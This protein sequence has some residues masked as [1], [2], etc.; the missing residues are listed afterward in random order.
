MA[1]P[2][3]KTCVIDFDSMSAGMWAVAVL[4]GSVV[5]HASSRRASLGRRYAG[6]W[7]LT[8][9]RSARYLRVPRWHIP[10]A[11]EPYRW[12]SSL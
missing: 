6:A 12:L 7:C 1:A 2:P 8:P 10:V 4:E 11:N 5:E 9:E 3:A